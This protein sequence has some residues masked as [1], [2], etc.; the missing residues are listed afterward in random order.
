M[1]LQ[2]AVHNRSPGKLA[3]DRA[4]APRLGGG[5]KRIGVAS[6][7]RGDRS[8]ARARDF[9]AL[10]HFSRRGHPGAY[11]IGSSAAG[12]G[13]EA[14]AFSNPARPTI[15]VAI[16]SRDADARRVRVDLDAR[17]AAFEIPADGAATVEIDTTPP[18]HT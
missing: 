8:V 9:C 11:R 1:Q 14:V 4:H 17:H 15:V 5:P 2:T 13:I 18:T 10:A 7:T 16:T 3:L 12:A 6:I